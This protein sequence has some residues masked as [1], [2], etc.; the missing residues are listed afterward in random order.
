MKKKNS[1]RLGKELIFVLLLFFSLII[2]FLLAGSSI[3]HTREV[4][5]LYKDR[6]ARLSVTSSFLLDGDFVKAL[7]DA[8]SS[9]EFQALREKAVAAEDPSLL[10]DYLKE[11]KLYD[12]YVQNTNL[13]STLQEGEQVEYLYV[14]NLGEESAMYLLDP[15]ESI[16][17]LG[18]Y[19]KNAEGLDDRTTNDRIEATV[20]KSE[21][22]WL[23]TCAEPVYASDSSAPAIVCVDLDMNEVMNQRNRFYTR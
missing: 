5:Q 9:Q 2:L 18:L 21:Y 13:L 4:D 6:A 8:V 1:N 15:S 22:G 11:K 7:N 3:T 14:Q 10:I 17:S 19:E 20:T 12:G 23:C 16:L